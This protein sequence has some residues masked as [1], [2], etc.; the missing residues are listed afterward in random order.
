[1]RDKILGMNPHVVVVSY[2]GPVEGGTTVVDKVRKVP[3]VVAGRPFVYGQAMLTVGRSGVGCGGA[4]YRSGVGGQVV[5]VEKH[6]TSGSLANLAARHSVT[7]RR[8]RAAERSTCRAS[9]SAPSWRASS[10]SPPTT[11]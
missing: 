10:G 7:L 9:S 8:R 3:G 4:R 1:M 5:D 11:S 6:L 2:G